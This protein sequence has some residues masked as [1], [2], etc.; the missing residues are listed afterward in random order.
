MANKDTLQ[1]LAPYGRVKHVGEYTAGATIYPGDMVK[2]DNAGLLAVCA[3]G[4]ASCLGVA[5]NYVTTGNKCNVSDDPEQ[6]YTVQCDD[7]T[8]AAQTNL[9]LNYDITVGTASTLYK[10]SA[11][12]LDASTGVTDSN[13][14]LRA[15]RL[16]PAV[17]NAFGS[18]ADIV[19]KLNNAQRGNATVGL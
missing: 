16:A 15:I 13:M 12:Q 1:G 2:L 5:L 9:G 18:K 4:T 6:E 7:G 8:V 10:R 17:D 19:V 11:M 3:A 14:P